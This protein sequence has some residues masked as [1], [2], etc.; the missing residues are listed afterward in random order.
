MSEFNR[1]FKSKNLAST[2]KPTFLK[3][4]L[5]IGDYEND[6]G[7]QWVNQ[8][9]NQYE[10]D[11]NFVA[12]RFIRYYWPL[13]FIFKIKQEA[14]RTPIAVYRIL[15]EFSELIGK[16]TRPSKKL[17]CDDKFAEIR[18]KIIRE[19]I[20]PQVLRKL[21]NDCNIYSITGG[22]NS[23][24]IS[25][26]NVSFMKENKNIL[27]SALNYTIAEYLEGCNTS[28]NISRC[29][30]EKIERPPKLPDAQFDE[31]IKIQNSCCFYCGCPE[32]ELRE[33]NGTK[34]FQDH[35][36]PWNFVRETKNY[37]IVPACFDCNSDKSDKLPAKEY[38][39]AK[40]DS[41][42]SL[43]AGTEYPLFELPYGYRPETMLNRYGDCLIEYHGSNQELWKPEK[44]CT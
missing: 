18:L 39:N 40:I 31:M 32:D 9:Q 11:L 20:K 19:G 24:I 14:T 42:K 2:Y 13:K 30:R 28:P 41:N 43:E 34:F 1:F 27:F 5:D 6:E 22:S 35:L 8:K 15:D 33:E 21:L 7:S 26:K 3:C 17:L 37:N 36:I 23:I 4:L 16:K 38:L 25:K 44:R 12:V 10:V 29:L